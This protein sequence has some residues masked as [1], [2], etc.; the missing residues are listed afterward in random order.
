MKQDIKTLSDHRQ[1][2]LGLTLEQLAR[3]GAVSPQRLAQVES[4]D[5]PAYLHRRAEYARLYRI[6]VSDFET[7]VAGESRTQGGATIINEK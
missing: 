1:Y 4:G 5:L 7:L 6:S 3:F 2:T